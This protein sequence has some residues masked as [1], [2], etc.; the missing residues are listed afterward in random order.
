MPPVDPPQRARDGVSGE[1][2]PISARD[3]IT[4]LVVP[5]VGDDT[6]NA[7]R[8]NVVA[9]GGGGGG[10]VQYAQ[11]AA[12]T[13]GDMGTMPLA[14]RND[15]GS[16]VSGGDLTFTPEWVT[17]GG[18]VVVAGFSAGSTPLPLL[19]QVSNATFGAATL[20][21]QG[22]PDGNPFK[23]NDV[24]PGTSHSNLGKQDGDAYTAGDVGVMGL[25]VVDD[26]SVPVPAV[27]TY[28]APRLDSIR[29]GLLLGAVDTNSGLTGPL[30][31]SDTGSGAQTIYV[32]LDDGA[33]NP[34]TIGSIAPVELVSTNQQDSFV[35][36]GNGTTI[37]APVS[38]KYLS[39]QVTPSGAVTSWDVRLEGTLDGTSWGELAQHTNVDG[40]GKI[41][42]PAT[43]T[44]VLQYR[45]RCAGL[46]LG[47]GTLILVNVRC[48][49]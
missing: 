11:G 34:V 21:V 40:S 29:G 31:S 27:G 37:A 15:T 22:D 43:A 47:A 24:V 2:T 5:Y 44:P 48:A 3:S 16:D 42:V 45:A 30:R 25:A 1:T 38:G 28:T 39:I 35:A 23:V 12:F 13:P 26:G 41:K 32:Q 46:V 14:V 33:V 6:N 36:V 7:I 18:A 8:V 20:V 17:D 4:G 10:G 19:A 9:G 49:T